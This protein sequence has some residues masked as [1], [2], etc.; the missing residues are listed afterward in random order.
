MQQLETLAY[1]SPRTSE[2]RQVAYVVGDL[3]SLSASAL[4][5]YGTGGSV[6]GLS[7]GGGSGRTISRAKYIESI[8]IDTDGTRWGYSTSLDPST[9]GEM[10]LKIQGKGQ[11]HRTTEYRDID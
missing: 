3:E 9:F 1:E 4:Y 11:K 2:A 10:S 7:S 5:G 8:E 6:G